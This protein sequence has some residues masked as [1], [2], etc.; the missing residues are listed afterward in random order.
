LRGTKR[1]RLVALVA[2]VVA[3]LGVTSPALAGK[4]GPKLPPG[5]KIRVSEPCSLVGR[6]QVKFV[7]DSVVVRNKTNSHSPG[8]DCAWI[9]KSPGTVADRLVGAIVYPGFTSPGVTAVDLLEDDR[10][11]AQLGGPGVI[12]LSLGKSGFL[13]KNQS[14]LEVAPTKRFAFSLQLLGAD[15]S[16]APLT[17]KLRSQL[18][19]LATDVVKRAKHVS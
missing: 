1:A 14:L 5:G 9:L 10:A 11:N 7:F 16:P 2:L 18:M 4:R 12:E 19:T 15:G 3:A 6:D 13:N 8:N 17:T